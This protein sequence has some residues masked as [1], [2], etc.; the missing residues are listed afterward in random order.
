MSYTAFLERFGLSVPIMQAPMAGVSTARM[1]AAVASVGGLGSLALASADLTKSTEPVFEEVRKFRELAGPKPKVN[2]NFF[3]H[4][5]EEQK[6]PTEEQQR[7]WYSAMAVAAN[8][9]EQELRRVVPKFQRINIS[10]REFEQTKPEEVKP[11]FERLGKENVGI[12]SFHFGLPSK[13]TVR[14]IHENN[15]AVFACVTSEREAK[16]AISVGADCLVCQG[17]NAGGHRGIFLGEEKKGENEGSEDGGEE[18]EK[19][20]DVTDPRE[21]VSSGEPSQFATADPVAAK[22]S[23]PPTTE[24]SHPETSTP[25]FDK[26]LSTKYLFLQ[27][28]PLAAAAGVFLL[29]AGG[30]VNG[31]S[32]GFFLHHGAAAVAVGTLLV[33]TDELSAPP[34]LRTLTEKPDPNGEVP[35]KPLPKTVMTSLV[36]GKVARTVETPFIAR[37]AEAA[38]GPFPLYGYLYW[39][40]KTA[41]KILPEGSGFYLAGTNYGHVTP[42]GSAGPKVAR[43]W[44][45]TQKIMNI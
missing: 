24:V 29:P 34:F 20:E 27:L 16:A 7:N 12:V 21:P 39:A 19:T 6:P 9:S 40:Y 30:I 8:V 1:A 18:K 45:E 44:A 38:K 37:L 43:L 26:K 35:P 41:A 15:I 42:G 22:K 31:A 4:D 17:Y 23:H 33:T 2:I 25:L 28:A 36:L 10:F 11:F 32:A 5:P 3:C 13:A 14:A